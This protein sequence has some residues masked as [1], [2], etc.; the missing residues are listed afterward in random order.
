MEKYE[1]N[2][3][4]GVYVLALTVRREHRIL[5]IQNTLKASCRIS[6]KSVISAIAI[7][8]LNLFI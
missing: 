5:V 7:T 2:I 8:L 4:D 6:F 1:Y 3:N